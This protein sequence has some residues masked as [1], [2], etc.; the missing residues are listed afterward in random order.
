[1]GHV[2]ASDLGKAVFVEDHGT[3]TFH[4]AGGGSAASADEHEDEKDHTC[5]GGP[6]AIIRRGESCGGEDGKYL[7]CRGTDGKCGLMEEAGVCQRIAERRGEDEGQRDQD[8]C[9]QDD[10]TVET[11]FFI[12]PVEKFF[13]GETAQVEREV[14]S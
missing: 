2:T 4:S 7:E 10:R 6:G 13:S 5:D 11:E 14:T 12:F 9:G 8:D 3:D 1:M